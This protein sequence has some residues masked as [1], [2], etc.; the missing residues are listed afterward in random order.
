MGRLITLFGLDGSGK[1][2]LCENLAKNIKNTGLTV[3]VIHFKN[4]DSFPYL[5]KA[6]KAANNFIAK[7]NITDDRKKRNIL[8]AY[9]F[10]VKARELV[11]KS[12]S[13]YHL[14]V[15]DR[16]DE[17]A[18]C[19]HYLRGELYKELYEIYNC[20]AK[21]DLSVFLDVPPDVCLARLQKRDKLLMHDTKKSLEKS[22]YFYNSYFHSF[23][24]VDGT[25][26]INETTRFVYSE[27]IEKFFQN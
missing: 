26:S 24:K 10:C 27:I 1:T 23:W 19:Y 6:K 25:S 22:Y 13:Q 2:T 14:T 15:I 3:N 11:T 17:S 8:S 4:I 12:M 21:A 16:Y 7:K 18:L 9:I 20:L 5:L